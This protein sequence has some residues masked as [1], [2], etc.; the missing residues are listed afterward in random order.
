MQKNDEIL[1][2]FCQNWV[3]DSVFIYLFIYSW[4]IFTFKPLV[5]INEILTFKDMGGV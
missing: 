2:E 4:E 1:G 5:F 3:S